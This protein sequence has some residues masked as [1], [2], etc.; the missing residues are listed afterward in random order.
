MPQTTDD[1]ATFLAKQHPY[2]ALLPAKQRE[3]A[4][5]IACREVPADG[6]IYRIGELLEGIYIVA[7]GEVEIQGTGGDVLSLLGPGNSFGERGLMRTGHAVTSARALSDTALYVLPAASFHELVQT[8]PQVARFFRRARPIEPDQKSLASISAADLMSA[9]PVTC[10]PGDDIISVARKMRDNRVSCVLAIENGALVGIVTTRDL[11]NRVLAEGLSPEAPV[12]E[13]LTRDPVALTPDALGADVL[14]VMLELGV[15][16]VPVVSAG[17]PVGILT[18]TDLTRYQ[19]I[20]AASLV[21]EISR[22]G[23]VR[24]I[25]AQVARI[26]DLLAQL[27]G[28]GQQ[29]SAVTRLVTDVGDAATRRLL[30]L[31]ESELGAPPVP[32]LWLACGSQGR[33][34]Q[35]GVSDQDNCLF[36]DDAATEEDD[37]YFSELARFVSDGLDACGYYYCPGDMMATNP[38]WRQ[39]VRVWRDY[40]AGWTRKPDPMAQMLASVM[41]DLRPIAGTVSLF[42]KLHAETLERAASNSIFV[43]HMASNALKHTPPLSLFRGL[44]TIRSGEHKDRVDLK[45]NGVVP[46]VDLARIYAIQGRIETASTRGRI[47]AAI[48]Q[49]IVSESGGRDLLDAYDVIATARLDHQASLVRSGEKPDNFLAP[50]G[51]SDLE[52]SHLRDAFVVVKTMQAAL[53]QGRASVM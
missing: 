34:E 37:A 40:F 53:G 36:L 10:A 33:Q 11:T 9:S 49:G 5:R 51:L 16:H 27:V 14:R 12:S 20:T 44:A 39:P 1:I 19:A 43:A 23:S 18:Q 6:Q 50:S 46:V 26:P 42:G 2:D 24:H 25:A 29:H 52:R 8:E 4:E 45:L 3:I 41:F 13:V 30:A 17:R 38:R 15:G 22:A 7:R 28:A 32:Y 48:A 47:E 21:L 31:A 35:T